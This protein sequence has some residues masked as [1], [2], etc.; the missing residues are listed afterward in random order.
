MG[1]GGGQVSASGPKAQAAGVLTAGGWVPGQDP[2]QQCSA[3]CS[4]SPQALGISKADNQSQGLTTSI[5]WGQTPINQSTPWDT[6]E[7]PSKQMRESDNPGVCFWVKRDTYT[8]GQG[9]GS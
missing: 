7:P 5:R 4:A 2:C 8:R 6:D 9:S 1:L 3:S